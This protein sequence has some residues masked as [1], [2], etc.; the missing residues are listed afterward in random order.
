MITDDRNN[1]Q[2]GDRYELT[3]KQ[4]AEILDVT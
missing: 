4:V 1:V 3:L 2:Y